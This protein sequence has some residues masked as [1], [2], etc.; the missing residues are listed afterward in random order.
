MVDALKN[1]GALFVQLLTDARVF[2]ECDMCATSMKIIFHG[3][4]CQDI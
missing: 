4:V 3:N 2:T 1:G